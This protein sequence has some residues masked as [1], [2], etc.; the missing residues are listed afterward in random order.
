MSERTAP[1][2]GGL[3]VNPFAFPSETTLRFVLLVIFVICG[4]ARLYGEFPGQD[5]PAVNQCLTQ[6]WS[7]LSK[8]NRSPPADIARDAGIVGREGAPLAAQCAALL[9]PAIVWKISGI[10]TVILVAALF[11]YAYP[12]W[13]LRRRRLQPLSPS[14]LPEITHELQSLAETARL[15]K[16]PIVVWN[17]LTTA[18]PV[19]FGRHG[20]YYVALS[21]SFVTQHFYRD[22]DS[23]RAIMLHEFAH[24]HNGDIPKTYLTLSLLLGFLA[25][26]LAPSLL[27]AS[28]NLA[29]LR[30][31]EAASLLING[32]LW[33]AVVILS[34]LAVLRAREFY[35]DVRA[36]IWNRASWVDHA[37]S[38]LSEPD[39]KGWRR[40]L[41][42]HPDPRERRQ[43]VEDPSRLLRLSFADTFG[44]GIAA[45]SVVDIVS[46]LL[47]PFLPDEAWAAFVFF[48]SIKLVVPAVVFIL[49]IG[50]IGIG[51]WRSAFSSLLKG[52]RPSKGTGWLSVAF[53]LGAFPGLILV[54]AQAALQSFAAQP[55]PFWIALAS[56]QL[57]AAIYIVLLVG[58]LLIFRW[59][60]EAA[61]AW[62][63]VVLR[64]RS[65]RPILLLSVATA[66]ILVVGTLGLATFV[67]Q[68]S[69][70]VAPWRQ[71]GAG[72][73]YL[74]VVA[75]GGPII[76]AS[77]VAWG[78]PLTALWW[79][80]QVMPAQVAHWVFLDGAVPRI[81][82]QEPVRPGRA[83][84]TGIVMGLLFLL[85]LELVLFRDQLPAAIADG[86]KS[87][88]DWLLAGTARV[89]GD[90]GFLLPG[91]G[92]LFQAIAAAI[93]AGRATRLSA[94][95]G[96]FAASVAG[97]IIV[98]GHYIL[99]GV[100]FAFPA[101]HLAQA[102]L[103]MMGLGAAVALP[104]VIVAAWIG[105]VA[106][107]VFA[108][109]PASQTSGASSSDSPI[110]PRRR[111]TWS[112]VSK[113]SIAA[114]FIAVGIG[115]AFKVYNVQ[116][117]NA[118]R[119]SA[120]R[121]DSDAQS[122][123]ASLYARGR[124]VARDDAQAVFWWRK[125]AEQGH[126]D[127]QYN[128]AR[129]FFDG[130]G[131]AQ[132][133]AMAAH[134]VRR[135]AEQGHAGAEA[136]LGNLYLLGRGMP[137]DDTLA[138]QWFGKAAAQ[139]NA[140]AQNYLGLFHAY[141]RGTPQDDAAAVEWFRKAA[142]QGHAAAQNNLGLMYLQGRA[143][144]K[145]EA[146]ALQW[147]L[148][149]ARQGHA[150]AQFR[151]GQAYEKGKVVA[152]DDE[153]AVLWFRQAAAKGHPEAKNIL[154]ILCDR[155]LQTACSP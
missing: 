152:K 100:G 126:A 141:G 109:T 146:Q 115:L 73:I 92:A 79:R 142:E 53:V 137:Q 127:A 93:V 139:G 83:L 131:V 122:R 65:P 153:Q 150:D 96:L 1:L 132:D 64:S 44:I 20:R 16:P 81:P 76:I 148:S 138:L 78:F 134:W 28:W 71:E 121:G 52:K 118:Y 48:A 70:V 13:E 18:L 10:C 77:L 14:E 110:G 82:A 26:T 135:A 89:F 144:P 33:T 61:S 5:D 55:L 22:R 23:F 107:R 51:V 106:R 67:V 149:A 46:G 103:Q 140:D 88:F 47:V 130:V 74:Y 60:S 105:Y 59:I 30:W 85:M 113:G 125:A 68:L 11:Y 19:V 84:T 155:G 112:L 129:M 87:A 136:G 29:T 66:L 7:G 37:L 31:L 94:V 86:I 45:W 15:P 72:G 91:S 41:R 124:G 35:A 120:E 99:L 111:A 69:F 21:G 143:L 49:A 116:A 36:S 119:T 101:S 40:Y 43:I 62:F 34:G 102:A 25:T 42:F 12:T 114:L 6:F 32:M 123:L 90:E 133:D 147:F 151:V 117:V 80:K 4:S 56:L 9:R 50:A 39:A 57:D 104:T 63:E 145:D 108:N 27:L 2:L 97:F 58:C 38:T 54:L 75:A 98:A 3:R 24:I 95:C 8:L 17:P 154:Q 128:L